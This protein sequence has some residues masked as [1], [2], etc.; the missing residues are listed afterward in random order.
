[1]PERMFTDLVIIYNP[2]STGPGEEMA[3]RLK[4]DLRKHKVRLVGTKYAGHA[5]QLAYKFAKASAR[6]L[7][8]SASGDG[9]YHEIINGLVKAQTEGAKPVAALL[10]AGNA[11]DHHR[12]VFKSDLIEGIASAKVRQI[13]LLTLESTAGGKPFKRYAHSYIGLGLTP[14]AGQ[15]LN[16]R[17]LNRFNQLWVIIRAFFELRPVQI[18]INGKKQAY[19]S[20]IF[21]NIGKM[22][23]VLL[24][25]ENA[26]T[27]DGRFEVTITKHL[28]KFSLLKQLLKASTSGLNDAIS[29][30]QYLFRTTRK[31]PVQLDGELFMLDASRDVKISISNKILSCIA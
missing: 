3:K 6:P 19:D 22:S 8:V 21:S 24:L 17:K 12:E 23:K 14:K 25:D 5:E 9:G 18:I 26:S 30:E 28:G 20:L 7:I 2:L 29:A 16:K 10:A 13:D 31:E 11:N 27:K 1:M 15:E 4:R